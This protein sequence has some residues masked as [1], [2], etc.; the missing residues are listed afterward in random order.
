MDIVAAVV[1]VAAD[2]AAQ[3]E[4]VAISAAE[5]WADAAPWPVRAGP[6]SAV[7]S[8]IAQVLHM[9]RSLSPVSTLHSNI[10]P[11]RR[12]ARTIIIT[13]ISSGA[14]NQAGATRF[15]LA[16]ESP[17]RLLLGSVVSVPANRPRAAGQIAVRRTSYDPCGRSRSVRRDL[18]RHN[19]ACI[20]SRFPGHIC[21]G[22]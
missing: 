1:V 14:A 3:E 21:P 18:E 13:R 6:L 8:P 15:L 4:A 22:Q 12:P 9:P 20:C 2:M 17:T 5:E 7:R 19:S 16:R 10:R 11:P